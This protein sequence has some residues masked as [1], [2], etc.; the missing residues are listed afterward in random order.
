MGNA[1][2]VTPE[3]VNGAARVLPFTRQDSAAL[4]ACCKPLIELREAAAEKLG[5]GIGMAL[6]ETM[7]AMSMEGIDLLVN[8]RAKDVL[9]S[10][11]NAAP[12][13]RAMI[14]AWLAKN[15]ERRD[16]ILQVLAGLLARAK[17]RWPEVK[18]AIEAGTVEVPQA[19]GGAA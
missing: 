9:R 11:V 17:E 3:I 18:A 8:A 12:V 4:A 13:G 15:T 14:E 2:A 1:Q 10:A 6:G 16:L 7:N 19:A 5:A